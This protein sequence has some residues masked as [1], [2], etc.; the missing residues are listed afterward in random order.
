[1]KLRRYA[2]KGEYASGRKA[3]MH[4]NAT[5]G[6]AAVRLV[7]ANQRKQGVKFTAY[8]AVISPKRMDVHK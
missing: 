3:T 1:M 8:S 5:H 2:V 4:I 6:L 7:E